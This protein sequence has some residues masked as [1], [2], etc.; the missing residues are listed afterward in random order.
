[1]EMRGLPYQMSIRAP[2][3]VGIEFI[4]VHPCSERQIW[5]SEHKNCML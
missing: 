5:R 4:A 3:A 1:M 2:A